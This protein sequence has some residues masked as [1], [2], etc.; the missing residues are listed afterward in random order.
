MGPLL[1]NVFVNDIFDF[2]EN[3]CML[4]NFADDYS[5]SYSDK[6]MDNL[7]LRLE[8][9]A[10]VAVNWYSMNEMEA[11]PSKFQGMI[12]PHGS[13]PLPT[14]FRVSNIEIPIETN[15]KVLGIFIDIDLNFTSQ[16]K[17]I[18]S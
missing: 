18:C 3:M 1:F 5:I 16:I 6:H 17:D 12:I 2:L 10:A 9:C 7:E 11:N 15:V 14:S 8:Q 13:T 4:Y